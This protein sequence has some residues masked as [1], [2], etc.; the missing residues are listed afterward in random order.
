MKITAESLKDAFPSLWRISTRK[1]PCLL[2]GT[3]VEGATLCDTCVYQPTGDSSPSR[4]YQDTNPD[5][6]RITTLIHNTTFTLLHLPK[7]HGIG[8]VGKRGTG[9]SRS[10]YHCLKPLKHD[11]INHVELGQLATLAAQNNTEARLRLHQLTQAK[12]L[13]IDDLGKASNT[14]RASEELYILLEKRTQSLSPTHW[15]SEFPGTQLEPLLGHR[16]PAI[17][18]RLREFSTIITP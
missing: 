18:R 3:P 17:I 1:G 16:G 4:P 2:C 8:I 13:L 11:H 9:K 7:G 10:L 5:D 15:T 14:D 6:P 12:H